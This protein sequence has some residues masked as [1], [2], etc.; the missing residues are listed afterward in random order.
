MNIIDMLW[1]FALS[2]EF[3]QIPVW[4]NEKLELQ[5]FID[6]VPIPVKGSFDEAATKI[7]VLLQAYISKFELQGYELNSDLVYVS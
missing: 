3:Q 5:K 2:V 6:W 4:E 7:N 1:L